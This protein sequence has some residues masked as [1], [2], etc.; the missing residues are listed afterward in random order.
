MLNDVN[1]TP[2]LWF[3]AIH[4][5][6]AELIHILEDNKVEYKTEKSQENK[7]KK[8]VHAEII[9]ESIK[10]HHNDLANYFQRNFELNEN[11]IIKIKNI[12]YH[13]YELI[14]EECLNKSYFN[15]FCK[16]K[17][18]K[19]CKILLETKQIDIDSKIIFNQKVC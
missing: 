15:D 19:F 13:N 10:C 5:N 14:N 8:S 17:Y 7:N 4:G 9:I 12:K 2:S 1:L 11:E 3:Y 18:N 16:Y 6:N